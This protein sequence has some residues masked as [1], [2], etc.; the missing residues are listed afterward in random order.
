MGKF[1]HELTWTWHSGSMMALNRLIIHIMKLK[2]LKMSF[3]M[4]NSNFEKTNDVD[5][6][7]FIWIHCNLRLSQRHICDVKLLLIKSSA[8]MDSKRPN[9]AKYYL[10]DENRQTFVFQVKHYMLSI[11]AG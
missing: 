3:Q 2:P 9:D 8:I 5:F 7:T 4:D 6:V 10:I 11:K 1:E